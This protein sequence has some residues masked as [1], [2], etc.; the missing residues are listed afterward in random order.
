[1]LS[2]TAAAPSISAATSALLAASSS[3]SNKDFDIFDFLYFTELPDVNYLLCYS[4]LSILL[5]VAYII[6][7]K[8]GN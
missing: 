8:K 1:M 5:V 7:H 4:I 3:D 6:E 2:V